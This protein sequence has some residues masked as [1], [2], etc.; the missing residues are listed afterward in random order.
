MRVKLTRHHIKWNWFIDG[1]DNHQFYHPDVKGTLEYHFKK[2]IF[3]YNG[4]E[5]TQDEAERINSQV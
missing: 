2:K 5:I 1:T 4:V 3:L